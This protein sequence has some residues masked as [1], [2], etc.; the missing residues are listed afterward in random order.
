MAIDAGLIRWPLRDIFVAAFLGFPIALIISWFYDITRRGLVRT[1]PVGADESFDKSLHRRDY[2]LFISLAA[3]WAMAI[4]Y[5]HTPAPVDK[6]IA[7]LPFENPGQDP[8][9]ALFAFG[10]RVDLQTQLQNI[11]DL[12][13]IARES[14]DKIDSKMS[15]AEIGLKL[16]AAYVMKGSVERVLDRVRINVILIDAQN[17]QQTWV[18]SYDREL[19]ASNWFDIRSEISGVITESLQTQLSPAEQQRIAIVPT[20]NLAALQAYFRGK[21][22]MAKRTT[23][24]LAE[25]VGHFQQAVDLDPD[26]ALAWVG[27]ADSL[28]LHMLYASSSRDEGFLNMKTAV[29]EALELDASVGEAYATLAVYE[30]Q[31]KHD[32][33]AADEAYKRALELNPNYAT[34]YQWYGTFLANTGREEEGLDRKRQAQVLDPLSAIISLSIGMTLDRLGRPEEALSAYKAAIEIDPGFANAY[35]RVGE[36]YESELGQLDEA[37]I[38]YRKAVAL[39]PGQPSHVRNLGFLYLNLGDPE[40]TEYWFQR[41]KALAPDFFLSDMIM[42]PLYLYLGDD[43]KL[44]DRS[45]KNLAILPNNLYS[46][47]ILRNY[48]VKTGRYAEALARYERAFPELLQE[49]EPTID[50]GNLE[51]AIDLALL[52]IRSGD[53]KRAD[54]L[55]DRSLTFILEISG[56]AD[57]FGISPVLIYAMQGKSEEALAELRQVV[58]QGWY[59]GWWFY[60]PHDPALDSI[61]DDP[62]FQAILEEIKANMAAQLE[63][64]RAMDANDELEPIPDID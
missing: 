33:A 19:N 1:P 52:L 21:Q 44:L 12:K 16:G 20:E 5:V 15:L 51:V 42:E 24:T 64:V 14:T 10:I 47:A 39:D 60:L 61:R 8:D 27:L 31:Y 49:D 11:S 35:E 57:N 43:V 22:R 37:I 17:E 50:D 54:M 48:D 62:E 7:I 18:S 34:A 2:L 46:L 41:H 28:Y 30:G 13:I 38:W 9:N 6:S 25:A 3:V 55:L 23:G 32:T 59:S 29:D 26:F 45:R 4:V 53:Q 56:R 40:E 36:T 63:R 58:D